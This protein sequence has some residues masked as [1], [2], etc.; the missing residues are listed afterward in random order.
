MLI[1]REN[2]LLTMNDFYQD[3]CENKLKLKSK[4]KLTTEQLESFAEIISW[5]IWQMD[6]IK[7]VIPMSCK[8]NH[9]INSR[10]IKKTS[11]LKV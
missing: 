5:N 1:A 8:S 4:T 10:E 6:G 9:F 11:K 2:I 3:F 7:C